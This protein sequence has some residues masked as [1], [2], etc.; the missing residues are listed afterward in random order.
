MLPYKK[1]PNQLSYGEIIKMGDDFFS[2]VSVEDHWGFCRV[3][4]KGHTCSGFYELDIDRI[5]VLDIHANSW[6]EK[7]S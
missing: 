2:V 3:F 4:V 7:Q 1:T 5:Q 6:P